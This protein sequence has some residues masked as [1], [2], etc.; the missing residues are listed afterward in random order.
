MASGIKKAP[1]IAKA[2]EG[3]PTEVIPLSIIHQISGGYVML[4]A[5]AAS[6]I[7]S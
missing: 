1:I 2:L 6:L 5:D 4:D 3:P 7:N